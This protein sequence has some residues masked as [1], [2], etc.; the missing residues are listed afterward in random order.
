[1]NKNNM[2][3]L[4]RR[5]VTLIEMMIVMFLIALITGV[6]A[7]NYSGTMDK[8]KAFKTEAGIQKLHA[9]LSLVIA[10]NPDADLSG[11]NWVAQIERSPLVHDAN[12]LTKD[13]W[14]NYYTVSYDRQSNILTIASEALSRYN[15]RNG[16]ASGR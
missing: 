8:G 13:G 16:K 15:Q 9:V 12:A 3:L 4:R 10:E 11:N 5:F 1:M 14:G 7:Y 6:V 2:K